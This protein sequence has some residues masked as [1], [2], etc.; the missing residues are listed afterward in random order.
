MS[1]LKRDIEIAEGLGW[2]TTGIAADKT[3]VGNPPNHYS[4][5]SIPNYSDAVD[6]WLKNRVTDSKPTIPK[7]FFA[8]P[9]PMV[10]IRQLVAELFRDTGLSVSG[11]NETP[12]EDGG[13]NVELAV[14]ISP[15][16]PRIPMD[17]DEEIFRILEKHN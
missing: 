2:T 12:T 7:E 13:I 9:P 10:T 1:D 14:R 3:A 11:Y 8:P 4:L 17:N 15:P 5:H 6:W 16:I